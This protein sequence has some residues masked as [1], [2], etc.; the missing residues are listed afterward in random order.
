MAAVQNSKTYVTV[1]G[2]FIHFHDNLVHDTG[3]YIATSKEWKMVATKYKEV[4]HRW[5]TSSWAFR[6][7]TQ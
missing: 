1:I 7:I 2:S 4:S 5:T 6:S 3:N